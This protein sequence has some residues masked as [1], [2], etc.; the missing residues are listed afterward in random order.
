MCEC[1]WVGGCVDGCVCACVPR[2]YMHARACGACV[3]ALARVCVRAR[4]YV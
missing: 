4:A 2:S 1:A 3:Y